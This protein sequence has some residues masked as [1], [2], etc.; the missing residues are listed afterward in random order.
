LVY[1]ETTK[2]KEYKTVNF[3]FL[4][5]VNLHTVQDHSFENVKRPRKSTFSV[6]VV[7]N[8]KGYV[9]LMKT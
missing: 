6:K 7:E 2:I 5:V 4:S 1:E 8:V 9:D 3:D